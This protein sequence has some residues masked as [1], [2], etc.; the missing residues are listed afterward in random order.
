M[1]SRVKI[2]GSADYGVFCQQF[3]TSGSHILYVYPDSPDVS[4]TPAAPA[5]RESRPPRHFPALSINTNLPRSD[6]WDWHSTKPPS[7]NHKYKTQDAMAA[8]VKARDGGQC[9]I[10]WDQDQKQSMIKQQIQAVH[11]WP[12]SEHLRTFPPGTYLT[13]AGA[14]WFSAAGIK[15]LPKPIPI[16]TGAAGAARTKSGSGGSGSG[17]GGGWTHR[18]ISEVVLP[19]PVKGGPYDPKLA[20]YCDYRF[21]KLF[22]TGQV[23]VTDGKLHLSND[24]KGSSNPDY[25][26]LPCI[27]DF[28]GAALRSVQR[29][30]ILR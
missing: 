5:K 12:A 3:A 18:V 29:L 14:K 6:D 11:V 22:E 2:D 10:T 23:W 1:G 20:I 4:S 13:A 8:V 16:A 15:Q 19:V 26:V 21:N 25:R 27:F 9:V 17:G 30:K 28:D 7:P 24:L